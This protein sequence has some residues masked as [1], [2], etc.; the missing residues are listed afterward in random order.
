MFRTRQETYIKV[1]MLKM[2][3]VNGP[4]GI[5]FSDPIVFSDEYS[6]LAQW[7][8]N[9]INTQG[10][11]IGGSFFLSNSILFGY[12]PINTKNICAT[13][14]ELIDNNGGIYAEWV[15]IESLIAIASRTKFISCADN[16]ACSLPY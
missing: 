12:D 1:F 9:Q 16:D 11:R 14:Q 8:D 10:Q 13:T 2:K 5:L 15:S 6:K 7:Y 3:L 4:D